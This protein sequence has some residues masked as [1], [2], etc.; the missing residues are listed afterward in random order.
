MMHKTK[1]A[2]LQKRSDALITAGQKTQKVL[3]Q[4]TNARQQK[5]GSAMVDK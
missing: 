3:P 2:V 1:E 5:Q 4:K